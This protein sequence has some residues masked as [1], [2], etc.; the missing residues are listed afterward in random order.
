MF[1][2]LIKG[3]LVFLL[4]ISVGFGAS[5][6]HEETDSELTQKVQD[7]MD[8]IVD[9]S[10]AIVDDV[11]EEARKDERVQEAEEFVND[12]NEIINNTKQDIEDHFGEDETESVTESVT[13][14]VTE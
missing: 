9:E 2:S 1:G 8:V 4:G 6:R 7:H 10:A 12:V 5:G 11:M 14:A 13:E 3:L